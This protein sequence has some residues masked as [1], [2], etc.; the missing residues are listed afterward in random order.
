EVAGE[1]ASGSGQPLTGEGLKGILQ[2][3]RTY[4]DQIPDQASDAA[5]A[6]RSAYEKVSEATFVTY[7][8]KLYS[9]ADLERERTLVKPEKAEE[10][11][12]IIQGGTYEAPLDE[13]GTGRRLIDQERAEQIRVLEAKKNRSGNEEAILQKLKGLTG[14]NA[15]DAI[16]VTAFKQLREMGVGGLDSVI[17]RGE[18]AELDSLDRI[19]RA[20]E[21]NKYTTEQMRTI[22]P[23]ILNGSLQALMNWEVLGKP[24]VDLLFF[25]QN[26]TDVELAAAVESMFPQEAKSILAR[27]GRN[28]GIVMLL[29]LMMG[30][31]PLAR[32]FEE[33]NPRAA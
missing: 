7:G 11:D 26:K 6:A 10:I 13:L 19:K 30:S 24:G 5:K 27:H 33:K 21:S 32:M 3:T 28:A 1:V 16:A 25:D 2:A 4:I 17:A 29:M 23:A 22:V 12:R 15:R 14:G 9:L 18:A 8:G 20:L 31:G